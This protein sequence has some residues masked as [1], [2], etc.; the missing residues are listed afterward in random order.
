MQGIMPKTHRPGSRLASSVTLVCLSLWASVSSSEKQ[1]KNASS[2]R[3]PLGWHAASSYKSE[4]F[5]QLVVKSSCLIFPDPQEFLSLR[6]F[7]DAKSEAQVFES[8]F[9]FC[10]EAFGGSVTYSEV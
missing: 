6:L 5:A 4:Q 3:N 1:K 8:N 9:Y 7:I 10:Q 2:T